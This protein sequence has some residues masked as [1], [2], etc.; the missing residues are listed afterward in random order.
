M[1]L[2]LEA[3]VVSP[4]FR[5]PRTYFGVIACIGVCI[6]IFIVFRRMPS[7]V[8]FGISIFIILSHQFLNLD[9]IPS[10]IG[11]GWYARVIIH[12]PNFEWF[13]WVGLYP[14]IPWIGVM[15]LGWSFGSYLSEVDI[16]KTEN[17]ALPFG[18]AGFLSIGFFFLV[19]WGNGYG[20][21]LLRGGSSVIE[22]LYVSKYPPSLAF[23]LWTLGWMSIF[24][25]VGLVLE[26]ASW[27]EGGLNGVILTFG[28]NPLFF[29]ITHLWFYRRNSN[30]YLEVWQTFFLWVIGLVVLWQ[31]C[32][33]YEK[34]KRTH[35]SW[36]KYI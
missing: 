22:W 14:I 16:K 29:Y 30:T 6:I 15:G 31:L 9:F 1:L 4:A 13:P 25:A 18:L 5:L 7:K 32:I 21:L 8:I 20:N 26:N 19:R 27:I 23:L 34:V 28:R 3:L 10:D 17:L 24:L 2:F 11:W 33:R 35:R 36:L 12:E